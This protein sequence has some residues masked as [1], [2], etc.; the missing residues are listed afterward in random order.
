[1]EKYGVVKGTVKTAS[2]DNGGDAIGTA[3]ECINAAKTAVAG[4]RRVKESLPKKE[5]EKKEK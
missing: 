4:L 2:A 3:A 1:M 5:E